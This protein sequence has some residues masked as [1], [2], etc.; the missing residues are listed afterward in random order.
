MQRK[1]PPM[2]GIISCDQRKELDIS[3]VVAQLYRITAAFTS[4]FWDCIHH[5]LFHKK[6]FTNI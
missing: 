2:T 3:A 4:L 1:I 6:M 5:I